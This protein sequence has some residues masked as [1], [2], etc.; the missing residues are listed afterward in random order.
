MSSEFWNLQKRIN[1]DN[2]ND[3]YK[4]EGRSPKDFRNCQ[5][6]LQIFKGLRDV[7]VN[8]RKVL[9][10]QSNFKSDSGEIKKENPK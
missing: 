6:M 9:K 10:K 3:M 5:Y 2:W 7:N 4:T 8:P 1:P